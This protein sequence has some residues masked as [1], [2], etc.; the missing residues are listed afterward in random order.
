M[1]G[2]RLAYRHKS[3]EDRFEFNS[4][5]KGSGFEPTAENSLSGCDLALLLVHLY[6]RYFG[7]LGRQIQLVCA[8]SRGLE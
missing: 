6:S 5:L 8:I 7:M 2:S 1:S 4:S 3:V